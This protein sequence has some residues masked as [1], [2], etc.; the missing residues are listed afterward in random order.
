MKIKRCDVIGCL[1]PSAL[2]ERQIDELE[3]SLRILADTVTTKT[4]NVA[5][6]IVLDR[7]ISYEAV[8][9]NLLNLLTKG[10]KHDNQDC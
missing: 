6:G 7:L 4:E 5:F 2:T 10:A 8:M 9:T 3:W 1:H